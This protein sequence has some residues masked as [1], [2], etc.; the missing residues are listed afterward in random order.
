MMRQ[1]EWDIPDL[2]TKLIQS[3]DEKESYPPLGL[4]VTP[5]CLYSKVNHF[6]CFHIQGLHFSASTVLGFH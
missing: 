3:S 2:I 5:C 4:F 6:D 1:A